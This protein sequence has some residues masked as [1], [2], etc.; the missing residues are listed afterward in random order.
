VDLAVLEDVGA[1]AAPVNQGTKKRAWRVHVHHPAWLA[2]PHAVAPHVA[3]HELATDRTDLA[4]AEGHWLVLL[5]GFAWLWELFD[6]AGVVA[7]GAVAVA[8]VA[9][10]A[11]AAGVAAGAVEEQPAAA[12]SVA[13]ADQA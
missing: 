13:L 11:P 3:D 9:G 5:S 1:Q 7:A 8:A 12:G 2:E 6:V 4:L 10:A